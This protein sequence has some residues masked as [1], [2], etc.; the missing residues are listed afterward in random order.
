MLWNDFEAEKKTTYKHKIIYTEKVLVSFLIKLLDVGKYLWIDISLWITC[1]FCHS[2]S[3]NFW[4]CTNPKTAW[5]GP[6]LSQF[7]RIRYFPSKE[8]HPGYSLVVA[9][10]QVS[11][12]WKALDS[13]SPS[14]PLALLLFIQSKHWFLV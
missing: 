8:Q 6:I 4:R 7:L 14:S 12:L 2:F 9:R 1:M 3:S 5:W 10:L 13:S 11:F